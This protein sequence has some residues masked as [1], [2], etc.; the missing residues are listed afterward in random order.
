MKSTFFHFIAKINILENCIAISSKESIVLSNIVIC[1]LAHENEDV[2]T[3]VVV[4]EAT[5]T[6]KHFWGQGPVG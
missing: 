2:C 3:R 1:C 6:I 5:M 4:H